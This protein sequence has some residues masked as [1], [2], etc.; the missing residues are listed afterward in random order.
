MASYT[1]RLEFTSN[2][3]AIATSLAEVHCPTADHGQ[4]SDPYVAHGAQDL[5]CGR[6]YK[7]GFC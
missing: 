4:T 2:L 1:E 6:L 5:I 7:S 3:P